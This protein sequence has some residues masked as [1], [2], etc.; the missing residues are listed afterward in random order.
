MKIKVLKSGVEIMD[1]SALSGGTGRV[2][3]RIPLA[4]ER[5]IPDAN[6]GERIKGSASLLFDFAKNQSKN[7]N[8]NYE[9]IGDVLPQDGDYISVAFRALSK[10][11]LPGHWLDFTQGDVLKNSVQMLLGATVYPN[12][13]LFDINN[14]LGVVTDVEWD[15]DG[16]AAGGVPGINAKYKIDALMNPRIARL[17]MMKPPAIHSTSMTVLFDFE[18]SHPDLVEQNRFWDLLG[19]EVE[20]SIVRLVITE[21]LEYWEASL[22]FQG[23]DRL[24][25]QYED[26]EAGVSGQLS[27]GSG[28]LEE[29][30]VEAAEAEVLLTPPNSNEEKTMKLTKEQKESLGIEFDGEDVPE[31]EILKAAESMA[32]K[33]EEVSAQVPADLAELQAQAAAGKTYI[34]LQRTEVTRLARLAELGAE[35]GGLAPVIADDI[36]AASFDRLVQLEQHYEKKVADRFPEAVRSSLEGSEAVDDAGGGADKPKKLPSV[37]I[38]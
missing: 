8:F 4:P 21:I 2:R 15:E 19:E 13:D 18:F 36:A 35:T 12:H 27:V 3:M 38:H 26:Q 24:A 1:L 33:V 28:Q 34:E 29:E 5:I 10:R 30:S 17:L 7:D 6:L 14:A 20:G 23:A 22:V 9:T 16:A 25:K 32:A 11:V 31:A 37:G